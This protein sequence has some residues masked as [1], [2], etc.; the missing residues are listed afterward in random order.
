MRPL[1]DAAVSRR[2]ADW[3][4]GINATRA[5]TAFNSQG[6]GFQHDRRARADADAGDS[7][8]A[9][10]ENPRLAVRVMLGSD[11]RLSGPRPVATADVGSTNHSKRNERR[12]GR[13]R[14]ANLGRRRT[15]HAMRSRNARERPGIGARGEKKPTTQAPPCSTISPRSSGKPTAAR[16]SARMTLQIA[17]ALYEKHKALTYPRTDSRYLPEDHIATA[18]S[19]MGSFE[20]R[21]LGSP[22]ASACSRR[23]GAAEQAHLQQREGQRSLCHRP[24]TVPRQA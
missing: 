20:D 15:A 9:R 24:D 1:A 10:G 14:R 11:R 17:Q 18:K 13:A 22:R 19:D 4:V 2:E 7:R 6:G 23:L 5:L 3:L 12:R 16:L 8:R 21:S